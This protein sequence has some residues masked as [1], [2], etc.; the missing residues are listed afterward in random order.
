MKFKKRI[1]ATMAVFAMTLLMACGSAVP[2][3]AYYDESAAQENVVVVEESSEAAE[4]TAETGTGTDEGTGTEQNAGE[5]RDVSGALTPDGSLSLVDDLDENASKELQ[6][7][8]VTTRDGS[9]YYIIIDR[10]GNTDNVYFLNAVDVIDL[11]NLMSDEEKE[12]ITDTEAKEPESILNP[13]VMDNTGD[14]DAEADVNAEEDVQP[15]PENNQRTSSLPILGIFAVLGVLIAGGYYMLK[16]RPK[17]NQGS[18]DVDREFYDDEEYENEDEEDAD[19][20]AEEQTEA[21]TE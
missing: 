9:Y 4:E 12:Q 2:A 18:I 17:K 11:M 14:T 10:S 13:L 3:F 19:E 1:G 21:T 6:F 20:S 5:N 15:A 7:M 16:I 8:T